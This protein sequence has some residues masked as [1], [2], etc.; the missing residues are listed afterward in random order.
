MRKDSRS[1]GAAQCG[2]V[3]IEN[4]DDMGDL[5]Q[6]GQ[7]CAAEHTISG[8][9]QAHKSAE[10]SIEQHCGYVRLGHP[11][12]PPPSLLFVHF[13]SFEKLVNDLEEEMYEGETG[14][15]GEADFGLENHL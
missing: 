5:T 9:R 3:N 13:I 8:W 15:E 12:A 7:L 4:L 2:R 11:F 14:H 6:Q 1:P 10:H